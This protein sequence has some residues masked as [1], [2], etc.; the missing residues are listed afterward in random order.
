[1]EMLTRKI[2]DTTDILAVF[3]GTMG[4]VACEF[5][6]KLRFCAWPDGEV[7]WTKDRLGSGGYFRHNIGKARVA[8][9][10][11]H[12]ES[13]G[14]FSVPVQDEAL[15]GPDSAFVT[16]LVHRSGSKRRLE[17]WHEIYERN[18]ACVC[19]S[20]GIAPVS[21]TTRFAVLAQA[22]RDYLFFRYL[23]LEITSIANGLIPQHGEECRG[24]L[25]L[26]ECEVFW[27]P[28]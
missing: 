14:I 11:Q 9:A 8:N 15:L 10:L 18:V 24:L 3:E 6:P 26:S 22:D 28:T 21:D 16:I 4:S 1:M 25:R 7:V 5:V 20:R 23:W 19:T 2:S 12:L 27:E 17:S 13:L